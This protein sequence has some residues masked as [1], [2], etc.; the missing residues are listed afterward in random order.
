MG[1]EHRLLGEPHVITRVSQVWDGCRGQ[2]KTG[3]AEESTE[4]QNAGFADGGRG[5]EPRNADAL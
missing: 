3:P 4:L 2:S 5:R 1:D